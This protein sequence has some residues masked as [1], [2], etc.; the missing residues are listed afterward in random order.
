MAD[1]VESARTGAT[2]PPP[3]VDA[4]NARVVAAHRD[5]S[6]TE[7]LDALGRN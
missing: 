7:V 6:R 3:D 2:G 4:V 5:A 1:L